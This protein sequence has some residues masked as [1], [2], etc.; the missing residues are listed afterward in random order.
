[1]RGEEFVEGFDGEH[2]RPKLVETLF[3]AVASVGGGVCGDSSSSEVTARSVMP[4]GTIQSKSRRS[5]V[6]L[7]ANPCDVT[8]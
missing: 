4:Q 3:A 5:V 2:L 8:D 6:T 1:V 7:S